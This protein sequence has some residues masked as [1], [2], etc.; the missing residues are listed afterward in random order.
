MCQLNHFWHGGPQV[1][2][3]KVFYLRFS[4]ISLDSIV[5]FPEKN[6]TPFSRKPNQTQSSHKLMTVA[7]LPKAN[8]DCWVAAETPST[9][10]HLPQTQALQKTCAERCTKCIQWCIT[11]RKGSV[12][13]P[14]LPQMFHFVWKQS[15]RAPN[16]LGNGHFWGSCDLVWIISIRSC[17][18]CPSQDTEVCTWSLRA[19]F[20]KQLS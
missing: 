16:S 5:G 7:L 17:R 6:R 13:P 8:Q 10:P 4:T 20:G 2:L 18:S 11:K 14:S 15:F 3:F 19:V 12:L 9:C 1:I